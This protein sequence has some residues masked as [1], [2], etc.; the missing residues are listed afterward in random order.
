VGIS[1]ALEAN[2]QELE[3]R[4]V[5]AEIALAAAQG[6]IALPDRS[7]V[8]EVWPELVAGL[9]EL[10]KKMTDSELQSARAAIKELVG[11]IRVTRDGQGFADV[12]LQ[13]MVA[14]AGFVLFLRS[15]DGFV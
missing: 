8:Q 13:S 10:P 6:P 4:K 11:E 15:R 9:G 7:R 14:G 3:K 1:P 2:L 5:D 12:C